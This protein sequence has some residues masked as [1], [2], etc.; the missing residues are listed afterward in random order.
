MCVYVCPFYPQRHYTR[1]YLIK[2]NTGLY[3]T[4]EGRGLRDTYLDRYQSTLTVVVLIEILAVFIALNWFLLNIRNWH[5]IVRTDKHDISI[6][7]K[8]ARKHILLWCRTSFCH[9]GQYTWQVQSIWEQIFWDLD[10][11]DYTLRS[12]RKS[13]GRS[14]HSETAHCPLRHMHGHACMLSHQSVFFFLK[15]ASPWEN[16]IRADLLSQVW[17]AVWHP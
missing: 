16:P 4:I 7:N 12:I 6:I 9:W 13:K 5:V 1:F 11:G 3:T 14:V 8:S 15:E 10:N 17:D 2:W